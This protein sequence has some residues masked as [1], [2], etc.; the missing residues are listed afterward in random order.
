M[1]T[2]KVLIEVKV[3]IDAIIQ[4]VSYLKNNYIPTIVETDDFTEITLPTEGE[5]EA[6]SEKGLEI[7]YKNANEI[8]PVR[9]DRMDDGEFA[10]LLAIEYAKVIITKIKGE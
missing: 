7:A 9:S 1:K 3:P 4:K 2:K 5:I 8:M 10:D 6:Y